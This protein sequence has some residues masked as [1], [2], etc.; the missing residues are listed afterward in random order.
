MSQ[1]TNQKE[2]QPMKYT[3][4]HYRKQPH[5]HEEFIKWIVEEH[6]PLA[7]PVFKKHGIIGYSLVS[8]SRWAFSQ[9]THMWLQFVTPPSLN[10]ALKPEF[11]KFRPTWDF[12]EFDCFIEY[13]LPSVQTIKDVMM[14]PDFLASVKDQE[15]WVETSKA[16]VSLGYHTPYLL[17]TGEVVNM[18]KKL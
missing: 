7:I 5:T 3:I 16:L 6:L 10:A 12:A 4:T 17:E 8:I 13:T 11:E 9:D 2:G 14:D 15:D 18:D 1:V